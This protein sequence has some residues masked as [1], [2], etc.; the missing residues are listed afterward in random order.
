MYE[1]IERDIFSLSQSFMGSNVDWGGLFL[2]AMTPIFII[3]FMTEYTVQKK[4][5]DT[6]S[7][8]RKEII[9]NFSL[10]FRALRI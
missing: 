5:G 6:G 9:T 3:A 2:M 8:N 10:G 1:N 7:F 4:N